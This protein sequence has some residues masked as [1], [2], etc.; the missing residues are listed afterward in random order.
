MIDTGQIVSIALIVIGSAAGLIKA[1]A[2]IME[3]QKMNWE[4]ISKH[5]E[6]IEK[7]FTR[8]DDMKFDKTSYVQRA[9]CAINHTEIKTILNDISELKNVTKDIFSEN[10]KQWDTINGER[11]KMGAYISRFETLLDERTRRNLTHD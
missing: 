4:Q 2:V 3:R 7:L 6:L 5:S 1:W 9:D 11:V 10:K 8:L